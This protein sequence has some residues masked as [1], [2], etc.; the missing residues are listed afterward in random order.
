MLMRD[1]N[2]VTVNELYT[3]ESINRYISGM[4][5]SLLISFFLI[6]IAIPFQS[7]FEVSIILIVL[8]LSYFIALLNIISRFRF[9][10]IKE[11][12]T[13]FDACYKNKELFLNGENIQLNEDTKSDT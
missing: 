4:F 1:E 6:I 11:V 7:K 9:I 10:R 3:A 2:Q 5:Y 12:Q 8:L 13:V